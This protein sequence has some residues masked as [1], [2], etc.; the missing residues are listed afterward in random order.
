M[1]VHGP[2][3]F[4]NAA[5]AKTSL[6]RKT[7]R[8]ACSRRPAC[9]FRGNVL[10][11]WKEALRSTSNTEGALSA[12]VRIDQ[13][14]LAGRALG[15]DRDVGEIERLLQRHHLGVVAREGGLELIDHAFAQ[16]L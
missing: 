2:A 16:P 10:P 4:G 11:P 6:H 13:K 9:N 5:F 14:F 7:K 1:Q 8:A 12:L 15:I 3:K